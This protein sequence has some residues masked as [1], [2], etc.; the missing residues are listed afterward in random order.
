MQLII[1]CLQIINW[2][3]NNGFT[4]YDTG[5]YTSFSKAKVSQSKNF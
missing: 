1:K 2:L 3:L 5:C 4:N